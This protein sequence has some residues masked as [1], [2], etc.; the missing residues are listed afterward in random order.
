MN[1]IYEYFSEGEFKPGFYEQAEY[2]INNIISA[3]PLVKHADL[4]TC[5][6]KSKIIESILISDNI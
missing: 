1:K 6:I 2:F 5:F 4:K 3:R